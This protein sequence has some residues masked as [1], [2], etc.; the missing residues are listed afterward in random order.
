MLVLINLVVATLL[1][2]VVQSAEVKTPLAAAEAL[3][4]FK[5]KSPPRAAGLPETVTSVPVL[6]RVRPI[7]ELA[8]SAL[9]ILPSKI[10]AEVIESVVK[11]P[12]TMLFNKFNLL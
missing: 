3:G 5:V 12:A 2:N 11:S 7:V 8:K 6:P 9:A 10:L 1:L 4:I